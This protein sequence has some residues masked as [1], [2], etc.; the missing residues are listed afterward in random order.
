MLEY[1]DSKT[2]ARLMARG[3]QAHPQILLMQGKPTYRYFRKRLEKRNEILESVGMPHAQ[4]QNLSMYM[5][6]KGS[7]TN[8]HWDTSSGVLIQ[9]AGRK[10]VWLVAP[11]HDDFMVSETA[12][13]VISSCYRRSRFIG[14][15]EMIEV[16]HISM[17]LHPGEAL[18]I[19][20]RWWHQIESLDDPTTGM[21]V[22]FDDFPPAAPPTPSPGGASPPQ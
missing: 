8:F 16:D 2:A 21:V 13:Q 20:A 6:D 17:V 11:E 10:R 15:E 9:F 4:I 5:S 3:G 18:Y 19:P 12:S 14:R 22:R 1:P 7:V